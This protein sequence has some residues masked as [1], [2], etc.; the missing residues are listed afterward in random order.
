MNNQL[1]FP[2]YSTHS[3]DILNQFNIRNILIVQHG[4]LRNANDYFCAAVNSLASLNIESSTVLIIAPQFLIPNDTIWDTFGNL[5][6]STSTLPIY[7][8]EG[9]KDG[10]LNINKEINVNI[11]S[12]EVYNFLLSRCLDTSF[13]PNVQKITLF[14]FSAG[15][16]FLQRYAV[17]PNYQYNNP[18]ATIQYIISDP[19]TFLYFNEQRPYSN[20][21]DG[22]A[23]PNWSWLQHTW[24][25]DTETQLPWLTSWNRECEAYN[26]WRYGFQNLV[27][28]AKEYFASE[29]RISTAILAY[30]ER[31][32]VYLMGT[33]DS[34]NCKLN[35]E[36]ISCED[37]TGR[38]VDNEMATY[39]QSML[40]GTDR[41]DRMRKYVAYLRMFY[42]R[43]VHSLVY[44]QDIPHDPVKYVLF[45]FLIH[46]MYC[47]VSVLNL[48]LE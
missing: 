15:A 45:P 43:P 44:A 12:Y 23:I 46:Y 26:D 28:Y 42:G 4:N 37:V 41:M 48:F 24:N 9:W 33:K 13:F 40:Q 34:C 6:T 7:A 29:V 31:N 18:L 20:G 38:C 39:C 5:Q 21:S 14:G 30:A 16:Q 11:F 27:G 32:I 22:F 35:A 1:Q 17:M 25:T 3:L 19:S 36:E 8:S 47:N 10:L 2:L